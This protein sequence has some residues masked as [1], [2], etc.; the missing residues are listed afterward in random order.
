MPK[1]IL[2][3]KSSES[4]ALE[5]ARQTLGRV[6]EM[7]LTPEEKEKVMT[8]IDE[9][10][11]EEQAGRG[12]NAFK[13]Y[14]Q[15]LNLLQTIQFE[16]NSGYKITP[17]IIKNQLD[18]IDMNI[19]D[20]EKN[21]GLRPAYRQTRAKM[22]LNQKSL[23]TKWQDFKPEV[24]DSNK[25]EI[26]SSKVFTEKEIRDIIGDI[27]GLTDTHFFATKKI[28]D[29][30]GNLLHLQLI[31]VGL[32]EVEYEYF[33]KGRYGSVGSSSNTVIH[34]SKFTEKKPRTIS[35]IAEFADHGDGTGRWTRYINP[36]ESIE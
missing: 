23:I 11:A 12:V 19:A 9:A 30:K 21:Y 36:L 27:E 22:L 17:E 7:D 15:L 2:Q 20:N 32:P 26:E 25:A 16:N 13:I 24:I 34:R 28:I 14:Q 6:K 10:K 35:V 8:M 1:E 31:Q 33:L 5:M 29:S 3:P 4:K 18:L